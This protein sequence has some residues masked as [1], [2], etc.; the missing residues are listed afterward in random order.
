MTKAAAAFAISSSV[1]FAQHNGSTR[2]GQ[3]PDVK[4]QEE[5]AGSTGPQRAY[6]LKL[7]T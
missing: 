2:F 1:L 3:E 7:E 4:D 5:T 6:G